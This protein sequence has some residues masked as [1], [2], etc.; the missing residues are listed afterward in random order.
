MYVYIRTY[1]HT[2]IIFFKFS[3]IFIPQLYKSLI[4]EIFIDSKYEKCYNIN[5]IWTRFKE[6][7]YQRSCHY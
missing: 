6:C 5:K 1:K 2:Y 3:L 7:C 4:F